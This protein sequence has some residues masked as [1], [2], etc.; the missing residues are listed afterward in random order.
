MN[1]TTAKGTAAL[2]RPERD[3][4]TANPRIIWWLHTLSRATSG[5]AILVGLLALLGWMLD[6]DFLKS[7]L[8]GQ[9]ATPP[10]TAIAISL[11]GLALWQLQ[12]E[13]PRGTRLR[14]AQVC[15]V[16]AAMIGLLTLSEYLFGWNLGI[17]HLLFADSHFPVEASILDR[18]APGTAMSLFLLGGA[19]LLLCRRADHWPT[20]VLALAVTWIAFLACLG[21]LYGAEL[22]YGMVCIGE[23]C[24]ASSNLPRFTAMAL[25]TAVM[26]G[27]LALGLLASRPNYGLME[28]V[29]S[30]S[31]GGLVAR[32]V[33]P[34]AI[35]IP[36]ALGWLNVSLMETVFIQPNLGAAVVASVDIVAVGG[37]LWWSA[38]SLFRIDM[39][40]RLMERELA[41]IRER[42][43][44]IGFRI[45]RTLLFDYPPRDLPWANFAALTIPSERIDGD[46]FDFLV[47]TDHH[48][49]VIL[50][51]VM[52]KGVP[53]ALL[54]AA[55]KTHLL[56]AFSHLIAIGNDRTVLPEPKDIITLANAHIAQELIDLESFVT[57]CYAR[58]D[59]E[60]GRLIFVDC[61]HTHTIHFQQQTGTCVL[62]EG[63]NLPLGVNAQEIYNQFEAPIAPGDVLVL[64]SDGLTEARNRAGEFFGVERLVNLVQA[65][66]DLDPEELTKRLRAAAE[67]FT[68]SD[69]FA[70]DL[71]CVTVKLKEHRLPG[72]LKRAELT[73]SSDLKE[74]ATVRDFVR[75]IASDSVLSEERVSALLRAVTEAASNIMIHAYGRRLDRRI[76]LD[77]EVFA[78]RVVVRFHH[79]GMSFDPQKVEPPK[80]D[81]TQEGGFGMYI[82][83]QSVDEVRYYLDDRGRNCIAL[84][85]WAD[86]SIERRSYDEE[87]P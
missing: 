68:G 78:D 11:I 25:P 80:F 85:K 71:T 33:L 30:D 79:L 43:I 76:E 8:A 29:S 10:N 31:A 61:G 6:I 39:Q 13:Q 63:D 69:R 21:H 66:A 41:V 26:L 2:E 86:Q 70:D 56:R 64:Y 49:D 84:I 1:G 45:Q 82:I 12:T 24:E 27:L 32:R 50:G 75:K 59:L 15:A 46:F 40:R 37:L 62:L 35:I 17:D 77:A 20:Q 67:A 28:I 51:D 55:T 87:K 65:H 23:D 81:G 60:R 53:A 4:I 52:G 9:D 34:A 22:L 72:P 83:A 58:F 7:I 16:G 36:T 48:I 5:L 74:L 14:V 18:M 54:G 47:H 38:R 3:G 57:V 19:L 44:E 73:L 42:E